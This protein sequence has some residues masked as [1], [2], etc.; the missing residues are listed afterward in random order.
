M[1]LIGPDS[2]VI[3]P[4]SLGLYGLLVQL[5]VKSARV[6]YFPPFRGARSPLSYC[7]LT[8]DLV[9]RLNRLFCWTA[10]QWRRSLFPYDPVFSSPNFG[11]PSKPF[12]PS[13]RESPMTLIGPCLCSSARVI[14]RAGVCNG[15]FNP[16]LGVLTESVRAPSLVV[17]SSG[18][19][20]LTHSSRSP[21]PYLHP[22][23]TSPPH[24]DSRCV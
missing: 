13:G 24:F 22:C 14:W 15:R 21:R 6:L 3:S 10:Q 19:R 11:G 9:V 23:S 4:P 16:G 1:A 7:L 5:M 20:S 8:S 2:F 18:Y 12:I 17:V